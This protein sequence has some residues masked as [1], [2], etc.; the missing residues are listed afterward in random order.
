MDAKEVYKKESSSEEEEFDPEEF[1]E[2]VAD[3]DAM[4]D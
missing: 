2:A 1:E 3:L 4:S